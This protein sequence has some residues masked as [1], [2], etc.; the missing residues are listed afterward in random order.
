MEYFTR[1]ILCLQYLIHFQCASVEE[2]GLGGI[3]TCGDATEHQ[4]HWRKTHR[5]C[6][7]EQGLGT[8]LG[9]LPNYMHNN[10]NATL[11]IVRITGYIYWCCLCKHSGFQLSNEHYKKEPW[12]S[13]SGTSCLLHVY[14]TLPLPDGC[15]CTWRDLP[16]L[17][18]PYLHHGSDQAPEPMHESGTEASTSEAPLHIGRKWFFVMWNLGLRWCETLGWGARVWYG[19]V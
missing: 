19:Y 17:P 14:L 11:I 1:Y 15:N 16:G 5:G 2:E 18:L 4:V 8:S 13:S 3:V 10:S 12:G 7:F 6:F 9:V